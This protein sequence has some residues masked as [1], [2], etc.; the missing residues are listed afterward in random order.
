MRQRG[1]MRGRERDQG[2]ENDRDEERGRE[3]R[4]EGEGERFHNKENVVI[5]KYRHVC[6]T[7]SMHNEKH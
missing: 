3:R 2:K 7:L 4:R 5:Y 1:K 6:T